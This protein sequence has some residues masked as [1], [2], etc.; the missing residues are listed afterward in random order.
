MKEKIFPSY[1]FVIMAVG[2]MSWLFPINVMAGNNGWKTMKKV[3]KLIRQPVFPDFRVSI[4]DFH[5]P[6]DTLYTQAFNDAIRYCSEKGGGHVVVPRG[7]YKTAAIRMLSNVDL[8]FEEGV[9]LLFSTDFRLYEPVLTR[10]EGIDC[11]NL[12]PLIYAYQQEN[13]AITGKG[14]LDGQSSFSTWL[15]ENRLWKVQ[16]PDGSM[17][18]EKS[19]LN[20]ALEEQW[21]LKERVFSGERGMRPQ[22]IQFYQCKNILLEDFELNNSP[23][24]LIHPLMSENIILRG[25]RLSSHGYNND[26]CDPESCRNVL[27]ENCFFD[28]GDDCIAIKSGKDDDGRKW[29][30]PSENIIVRNCTMKDGHAAV[31]IGSEITGGCTNVWVENCR[32]DSP[33]LVRIIR[34]KSN[35]NRG[36][37]VS[38]V[39]VRNLEVG[40]CDLAILG[41]E[42]KYWHVEEGPYLP[43]FRNIQIENVTSKK[44][45]YLLHIDGYPD[46]I[47]TTD[48]FIR[49]CRFDGVSER[50]VN[51][52]VGAGNIKYKNVYVN[53]QKWQ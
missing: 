28:T 38:N 36:G 2:A 23:F 31:A 6:S 37:E 49:N 4:T 7:V 1:L 29:M 26:G 33:N 35:P 44:S 48:I 42:M 13:M 14:V 50:E 3:E 27:I 8:H 12:S 11:Y 40:T 47:R 41:I 24:W 22:F 9:K 10:I 34:I 39:Y 51:K 19:L 18:N 45:K 32:M 20:K 16:L 5:Q 21:P 46:I 52:I 17:G 25:L 30:I 43:L 15:E 53:G